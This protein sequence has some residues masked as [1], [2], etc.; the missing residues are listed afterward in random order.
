MSDLVG[1]TCPSC[2][3]CLEACNPG[4]FGSNP[5]IDLSFHY[6]DCIGAME[7]EC[8][9]TCNNSCKKDGLV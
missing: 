4:C 3:E 2:L 7:Y 1:G 5:G 9:A 8:R 6:G